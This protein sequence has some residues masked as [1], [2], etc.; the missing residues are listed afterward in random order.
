MALLA[1]LACYAAFA[2]WLPHDSE[3][4]RDFAAAEPC[5][6]DTAAPGPE[7]C[8]RMLTFTVQDAT[9]KARGKNNRYR[10]T[11]HRAPAWTETVSFGDPRPLLEGLRPGDRVIGTIWRGQITTVDRGGTRQETSE[12]PRHNPQLAASFGTL[13][14]LFAALGF[15]FG[16]VRLA[17]PHRPEPFVWRGYGKQLFFTVLILCPVTGFLALWLEFPW[18]LVP[19]AVVPFVAYTARAFHQYRLRVPVAD[20]V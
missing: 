9:V 5:P 12:Q 15:G 18:W 10:A 16:A 14:G 3:R 17:R 11:L 1:A 2:F 4:Y 8:L 19:A 6:A 13:A 7:D 20:A